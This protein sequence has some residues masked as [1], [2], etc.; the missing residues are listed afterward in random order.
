MDAE[1]GKKTGA[2]AGPAPKTDY[3]EKYTHLISME[4]GKPGA[5]DVEANK[6]YGNGRNH[7]WPH[8]GCPGYWY[9]G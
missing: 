7:H 9:S 5:Q 2:K 4:V 6:Q 1:R 8:L 3:H